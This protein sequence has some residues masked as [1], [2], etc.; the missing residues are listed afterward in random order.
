MEKRTFIVF[1]RGRWADALRC[2]RW[3]W[4]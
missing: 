2:G 4:Q 3:R 1:T